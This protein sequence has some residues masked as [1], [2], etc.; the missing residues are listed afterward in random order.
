[1]RSMDTLVSPTAPPLLRGY[2]HLVGA[3]AAPGALLLLVFNADSPR[4]VVGGAIFGA[5]LVALYSTSAIYHLVPLAPR[6]RSVMAGLDR[7]VIFV[8]IAGSYAPF[9]LNLLGDAWGIPVL[10]VVSGL[11]GIGIIVT[12]AAPAAPRWV[13]VGLYLTIGWVGLVAITQLVNALPWE[14]FAMLVLSGV[15]Y[16]L[17]GI[18]Y[19]TRRPDPFPSVFGYHETFHLLQFAATAVVYLV[20]FN[21]VLGS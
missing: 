9:A 11:A 7:S 21:Y 14:G 6:L 17:G 15:L 16:S 4:E 18:T 8:F 3:I 19:A 20:V 10:S 1:M 5:S 13:R 2:L 12:L